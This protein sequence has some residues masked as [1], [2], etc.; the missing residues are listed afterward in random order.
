M[1]HFGDEIAAFLKN[2]S[3]KIEE[4]QVQATLGKAEL[5]DKLEEIKKDTK[6]KI[7]HFKWDVNS[8][9]EEGKD[10]Y[11]TLKTKMEHLQLQLAL[12]KAETADELSEQKKKL[13]NAIRDV[14]NLI[15]KD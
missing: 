5:A 11:T 2:A 9:V 13:S 12:G 8:A 1:K 10:V 7:N 6:D 3:T 4:L 15:A 14:K